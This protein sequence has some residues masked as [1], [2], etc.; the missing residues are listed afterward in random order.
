M[1]NKRKKKQTNPNKT[2]RA[3]RW[4][5]IIATAP[6]AILIFMLLLTAFGV[7]GKL[8]SFEELENPKSNLATEIY[9][10]DGQML[11]SFFVQNR[12]YVDYKDL[13]DSLVAAL[14]STED[15]RFYSHSGIDF[16]SLARVGMK[17]VLMGS[18]QQGGGSTITQQL[19]KNLFP[20]DTATYNNVFSRGGKLVVSKLKEWITAVKLEYNY[21]KEEIIAMYLNTVEFGSNAFGIKSAAH[22][23]FNKLPTELTVNEAAMLVGVV[24]APTR[25]SPVINPDNALKR[26]NTVL[27]RMEDGGFLN[28]HQHDSLSALP[29]LL[30]YKPVSHNQGSGTYFREMLRSV[31]T[32]EQPKRSQYNTDWDYEQEL[33]RWET[34]PLYGWIYKNKKADGTN[35]NI[36]RDGLRIYTTINATMQQYA[37]EAVRQ[38]L[39]N[40][41]QPAMEAQY[42]WS[43][44]LFRNTS[45]ADVETIIR[46]AMRYTERYRSL[47][48]S[49]ASDAEIDNEFNTPVKM[50]VFSYKG[51]ID[52]TMTPRDSILYH[53]RILRASFVAM[54][55]GSGYV[56]A[57]VGGPDF[58]YFKYDMVKQGKRQ[59]GSTI[60]PFIYTFAIDHLGYTPCTM[61]PNLPTTIETDTGEPW[62]PKEA[63][64]NPD[65]YD[66]QMKP[67]K[68]GLANSRNNYSAWIMKQA[69]QPAAVADFIH[70]MGIM[71]YIYPVYAL[72]LGTPDFSLYEMVGAYTTFVNRGVFIDP[73]F[74]VRIED[75]L[76]NVISSFAPTSSDAISEQTAYTMLGMLQNVVNAGTAGKLHGQYAFTAQMGGKTG[77]SQEN[78]DAWF[79][80][81]TPKIVA[82]AWVG[83]EDQSVHL[84][85]RGEGSA[86]ALPI[87]GEFMKRV[88]ADPRLGIKQ[89]DTFYV[90][91]GAETYDCS[92]RDEWQSA[93]EQQPTEDEFFD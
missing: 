91:A 25:Y 21:T 20:R 53:K 87:F 14:V 33:H 35:Y 90:P 57:Y 12:S 49:G 83:G 73:T 62:Q 79:I 39:A 54:E 28:K 3:V 17:T 76:G 66:G 6:F 84:W 80:G 40:D 18:R 41:I 46:N 58:R 47:K 7:F 32:A 27:A 16:I 81:V 10:E 31:M 56:R 86:L 51:D 88:Y 75:R 45:K 52:T 65:I 71:S 60:K 43:K 74:V 78:R 11:G 29:I 1:N 8:P 42:K 85:S 89:T 61:V 44:T 68:W 82:G 13:N 72:C 9:S 63:G 5:W 2:R 48:N 19:A 15:M 93:E 67:L 23:F 59:V 30:N 26:R 50:R 34:N 92:N 22:T 38:R 77:T 55:P 4:V 24:N 70:R 36:Y 69:K 37:E 64:G